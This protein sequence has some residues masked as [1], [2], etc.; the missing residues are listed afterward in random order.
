LGRRREFGARS[1]APVPQGFD[2]FVRRHRNKTGAASWTARKSGDVVFVFKTPGGGSGDGA[3]Q[4]R[5][6]CNS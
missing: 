1:I 6:I 4:M 3:S 2:F 5:M